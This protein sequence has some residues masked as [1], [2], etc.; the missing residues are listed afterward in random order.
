[1]NELDHLNS[2]Q[3]AGYLDHGLSAEALE[4]L[5]RHLDACDQCRAELGE[6]GRLSDSLVSVTPDIKPRARPRQW[7]PASV[8]AA[9]AAAVLL[10][11]VTPRTAQKVL[12][13]SPAERGAASGE[14][15]DQIERI[16]PMPGT[17]NDARSLTFMWH[18]TSA[19][20]YKFTLLDESGQPLFSIDTQDPVV[21]LPASVTL[22]P[23]RNYFWRADGTENGVVSSTGATPF[24]VK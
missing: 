20:L 9:L 2:N 4:T 17:V 3:I 8:A 16:S 10:I 22:V 5:E 19:T 11:L 21:K 14:G 6:L 15:R 23:G 7:L 18:P 12:A 1:M 24:Q 13:T